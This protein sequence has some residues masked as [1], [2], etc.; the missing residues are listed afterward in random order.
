MK[1][2]F[3]LSIIFALMLSTIICLGGCDIF[4]PAQKSNNPTTP[5]GPATTTVNY[6]SLGDSI[7]DGVSLDKYDDKDEFGFVEGS[8]AY[9]YRAHLQ[10]NYDEVNAVSYAVSGQTSTQLLDNI[11]SISGT[12]LTP[13][14]QSVKEDIVGADIITI[15]IGANDILGPASAKLLE[16]LASG[17]DIIDDLNAGLDTFSKNL[18]KI[19]SKLEQLNPTAKLVFSNVYNPYKEYMDKDSDISI[20]Y[21]P[22][23][24]TSISKD[25]IQLMGAITEEYVDSN[26]T[27]ANVT[28]IAKGLNQIIAENVNGKD[29]CALLDVKQAF[30]N[31]FDR[32]LQTGEKKYDVVQTDVMVESIP[33]TGTSLDAIKP[34]VMPYMDPHPTAKGHGLIAELLLAWHNSLS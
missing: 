30:D 20:N 19:I 27:N 11:N 31:Y 10:E 12:E 29:N 17:T 5:Q 8:Y 3:K 7:P 25:R 4:E 6:V 18:P 28:D 1:R 26:A 9:A 21:G 24:V 34:E 16:F 22:Y 13:E 2:F 14:E 23:P 32:E 15:C 33:V